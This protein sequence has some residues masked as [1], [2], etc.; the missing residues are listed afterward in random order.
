[1]PLEKPAAV[2][3]DP[4]T[5]AKWGGFDSLGEQTTYQKDM[6]DLKPF[7]QIPTLKTASGEIRQLNRQ[8]RITDGHG[9]GSQV[10]SI[11]KPTRSPA[12]VRAGFR[13]HRRHSSAHPPPFGIRDWKSS[14]ARQCT[15]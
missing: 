4:V 8:L 14:C 5:I 11:P 10:N 13:V 2:T 7:P 9:V 1:M 12:P 6:G 15:L 3:S